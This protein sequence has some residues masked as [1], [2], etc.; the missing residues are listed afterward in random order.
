MIEWVFV[1]LLEFKILPQWSLAK[2]SVPS[3]YIVVLGAGD[4]SDQETQTTWSCLWKTRPAN[5]IAF[6]A[7]SSDGS[8]FATSGAND[9]LVRVWYQN[10][11]CKLKIIVARNKTFGK[12]E[13]V[14]KAFLFWNCQQLIFFSLGIKLFYFSR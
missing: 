12:I 5:S 6:L 1:A 14:N 2:L 13:T 4:D 7:Y 10:Q 11:Q 3:I 8:L 9:R